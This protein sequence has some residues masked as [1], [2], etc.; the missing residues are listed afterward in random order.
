MAFLPGTLTFTV[1]ASTTS[2]GIDLGASATGNSL[3]IVNDTAEVAHV[4]W[5]SSAMPTA[6]FDHTVVM[7]G[8]TDVINVPSTVRYVAVVLRDGA[9]NVFIAKGTA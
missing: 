7:A 3:R 2:A 8:D 6:T 5:S 4:T 9:G 1:A